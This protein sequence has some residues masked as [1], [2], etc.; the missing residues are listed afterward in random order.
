MNESFEIVNG[1][2]F[3]T[4]S[5]DKGTEKELE[6]AL[7]RYAKASPA[8][9]R[10]VDMSNVK[11]LAPTGGK[12]VIT[13]GQEAAEKGGSLR[14]L[15][16]RGVLQTLNLL[17]AKAWLTIEVCATPNPRPGPAGQ[18]AT[19]AEAAQATEA[20]A[21]KAAEAQSAAQAAAPGSA[22]QGAAQAPAPSHVEVTEAAV[23]AV[24]V[25]RASSAYAGPH[26]DLVGGAALLRILFPNRRYSFHL[27][28]GELMLGFVRERVGGPWIV[29]E[30]AGTRKIVNLDHVAYCEIL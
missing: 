22:A 18:A 11:W 4:G 2:L 19:G 7:S 29:L 28:S 5:L 26:E 15:A 3:I 12:A 14:V 21:P 20:E 23:S 8:T 30:T 17:G 13:A 9:D 1:M 10:V 24:P 25:V 27:Q 16:S 6:Q